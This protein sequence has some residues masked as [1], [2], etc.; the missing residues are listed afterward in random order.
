[1]NVLVRWRHGLRTH[2]LARE[3]RGR[4]RRG[5]RRCDRRLELRDALG[6]LR[7][8]RSAHRAARSLGPRHRPAPARADDGAVRA[9]AD[10][11]SR[12]IHV[13]P[14][15]ETPRA[16]SEVRLLPPFPDRRARQARLLHR[17]AGWSATVF[18]TRS[19]RTR[20]MARRR[21]GGERF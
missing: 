2:P 20:P 12:T 9:L 5:E 11:P 18:A 1:M 10:D 3:Y 17:D 19:Q 16:L 14:Q 4:A 13:L 8:F 6:K 15:P 21:T 7:L